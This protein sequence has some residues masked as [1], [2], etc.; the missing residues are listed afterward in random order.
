MHEHVLHDVLGVIGLD[1]RDEHT[2]DR[3]A[4]A[5][6]Q[7]SKCRTITESRGAYESWQIVVRAHG[8]ML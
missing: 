8:L 4:V 2:M 3:A 6:V 5:P 7:L 1:P